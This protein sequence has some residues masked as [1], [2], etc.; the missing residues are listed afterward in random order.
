[1]PDHHDTTPSSAGIL[2][3]SDG[4]AHSARDLILLLGRVSLGWI[5]MESGW[6][7]L[8]DIAGFAAT[9]PRRGLPIYM[10]YIAPPVEFIGGL[11][12]LGGIATRYAALMLLAFTI[13][14]SVSSH[15]FWSYPANDMANR[16]LHYT[17]FWKNMSIKG[18]L[19]LLFVTAAGKFSIDAL[20]RRK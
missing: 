16:N 4:L 17:H 18:G 14:A 1:M 6:R 19:I 7:K 5:F 3:L 20:L 9:M 12:V 10:G 8:Q 2:S 13:V 15:A 11:M